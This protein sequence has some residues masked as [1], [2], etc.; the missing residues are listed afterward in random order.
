MH[1]K[2]LSLEDR[3]VISEMLSQKMSFKQIA[4]AVGKNCTTISREIKNHMEFK[5]TGGYGRSFNACRF[6]KACTNHHL[7]TNCASSKSKHCPLCEK[8]NSNCPDFQEEKCPKLDQAPY[9]CNGCPDKNKCTL[10]KR[11]YNAALADQ[12][13]RE[14]L[15]ESR[16]GISYSEAE[17]KH[18]DDFISP[19]IMKG[20]SINHICANNKRRRDKGRK[21]PFNSPFC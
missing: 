3:Y 21:S 19:L 1:T 4:I 14:V 7:C 12:E 16:R 18:L 5:K 20:Q 6:R 9:V 10:E 2:H 17:I 11:Y 8:C 15:S 13:Y